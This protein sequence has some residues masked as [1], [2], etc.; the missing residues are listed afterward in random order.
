[1]WN[2]FGGDEGPPLSAKGLPYMLPTSKLTLFIAFL[3]RSYHSE[4]KYDCK[5]SPISKLSEL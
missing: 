2:I 5:S 3:D 4:S 1:M